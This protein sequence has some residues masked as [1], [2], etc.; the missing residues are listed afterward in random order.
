MKYIINYELFEIQR[1]MKFEELI[2]AVNQH[3]LKK[4]AL[5]S[6]QKQI[7]NDYFC[8]KIDNDS[9]P[10][11]EIFDRNYNII[12]NENSKNYKYNS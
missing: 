12:A 8:V 5:C 10:Q 6:A 2:E 3:L 9:L 4:Y 1:D 11:R 7:I